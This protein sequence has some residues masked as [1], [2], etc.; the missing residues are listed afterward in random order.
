[1]EVQS[2]NR[3]SQEKIDSLLSS[4]P[5]YKQVKSQDEWQYELLMR[6]SKVIEYR[7]GEVV[8]ERGRRDQWLFF[9]L[10]GQLQV[11]VGGDREAKVVN[12]ITPGE[13][14]GDLAIL[15]NHERSATVKSD[16]NSRRIV[17]FGTNFQVFGQLNDFSL[18][19]LAT[20]LAYFRNMVH[21]L[22]W[23]LEMYRT[24]YPENIKSQEHHKVK[25]YIGKKDCFEELE[26]LEAQAREL[27]NLLIQWNVEFASLAPNAIAHIDQVAIDA[28]G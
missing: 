3:F 21:N 2:L 6:H 12:Y 27:A 23:K 10:K 7:P 14:F 16:K 19:S 11:V 20:K 4:I 24:A 17:V 1:M 22:R 8:L 18:I 25:L 5:F 13:V 26:A 15:L 9:L 28:F